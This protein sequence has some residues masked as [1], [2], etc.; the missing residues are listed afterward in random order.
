M[1]GEMDR[2]QLRVVGGMLLGM[3]L[4]GGLMW[5][6]GTA[7]RA[8][9]AGPVCTVDDDGAGVDYTTIAA[10]VADSGC[11]TINVAAGTYM[12]NITID[13]YVTIIGAGADSVIIDGNGQVTN[14]RVITVPFW[15]DGA[16]ISGVTIRNGN[17]PE[18]AGGGG[19]IYNASEL[20]LTYS[21]VRDNVVQGTAHPNN[22]G[23][24]LNTAAGTLILDNVTVLSNT[25]AGGGGLRSTGLLTVHNST[26][27][28][29]TAHVGGG[30]LNIYGTAFLENVTTSDNVA[31]NGGAIRN[32]GDM[33]LIN[34][35]LSA[36]SVPS[37]N[38]ASIYNAGT[39]TTVNTIVASD[40]PADNCSGSGF[41]LLTSLGHNLESGDTCD[42]AASGDIT[43]TDPLL[44]P[45]QGNGGE[46]WTHALSPNSPAIDQGDDAFCPATDQ[47]GMMR[48][49]TCDIGAFEAPRWVYLPLVL[50][51]Y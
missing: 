14:R 1:E 13:R 45:L 23:G 34:C 41:P 50:R 11:E 7:D 24:I 44:G 12:E 19:G 27:V 47:R 3:A 8:R 20:T 17:V 43:G 42:L 51:N 4:A 46:T 49:G 30:A 38:G 37:G 10:A 6:L 32:N 5:G 31:G 26:F 28:L 48:V 22:G 25:A 15:V 39:M 36:D 35:T 21:V 33:L 16:S 2:I 9:A 40:S 29:N 18:G